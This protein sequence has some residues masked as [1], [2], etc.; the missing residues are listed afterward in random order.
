VDAVNKI[1]TR[2]GGLRTSEALEALENND[3]YETALITLDYYDKFY[4]KGLNKRDK[5]KVV[6]IESEDTDPVKNAD[7][8]LTEFRKSNTD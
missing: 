3:Y 6:I 7:R 5:N 8:V 1:S 4:L 2:L